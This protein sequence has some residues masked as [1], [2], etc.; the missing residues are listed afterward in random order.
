MLIW[1]RL[2]L[3]P[4]VLLLDLDDTIL[5][6]SASMEPTWREMC[7]AHA[8]AQIAPEDLHEA[9]LACAS[10]FWDDPVRHQRGRLDL[11]WSRRQIVAAAFEHLGAN[12]ADR[13]QR[14]ADEYSELRDERIWLFPGSLAAL[15]ALREQDVRLALVTNGASRPQRA[16]IDRFQ[17]ARFFDAILIEGEVGAGK[18]DRRIFE[19]ALSKMDTD[20]QSTWMIGD[21]LEADIAGAQRLGIHAIWND[22]DQRGQQPASPASPARPDRVVNE[23][24]EL[25]P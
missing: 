15:Q 5:A 11:T 17:L 4:A 20:P 12:D 13:A 14:L 6:S 16:K 21:S 8:P 23:I 25:I 19:Q 3:L 24:G 22:Y 7:A 1:R 10:T 18:P 9:I 2:S